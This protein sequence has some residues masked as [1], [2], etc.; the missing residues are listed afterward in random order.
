MITGYDAVDLFAGIGGWSV[1]LRSLGLRALG[2]EIQPHRRATRKAAGFH[3]VLAD[4]R[5]LGHH[6]LPETPGLI[7]SPPCQTF[8]R[9]GKGRGRHNLD[10][11]LLAVKSLEARQV[12]EPDW[13]DPR[14]GLVTEP[15]RWVLDRADSGDPYR[16]VALEQVQPVLPVWQAVGDV[17]IREG[18]SVAVGVVHAEQHGVPQT[19]ARAVL[20]ARL[21]GPVR[22]P[23][24]THSRFYV[25]DR[26]RLDPG[27]LPWVSMADAL[28]WGVELAPP[29][30]FRSEDRTQ[31]RKITE[32]SLTV[33]FGN[34]AGGWTWRVNNQSGTPWDAEFPWKQPAPVI[35]YRPLV[36]FPGAN[37]NRFN[38]ATKSR[39][40]GLR[41][42]LDEVLRLQSFPGDYP[43]QG[44]MSG[45]FRQ[46]GDA[47]PP[48][49]ARALL[50][51]VV[52]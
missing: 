10:Q 16:W 36:T 3:T 30:P 41:V 28:G 25:K 52:R 17:L 43:V 18:Y 35:A 9:A 26:T 31:A 12:V 50:A 2:V 45:R 46:V 51:E 42:T 15:L 47:I 14:T 11:V 48:L 27:V 6:Q 39:N 22:L 34:N 1:G 20:L 7:A 23:R 24:P 4:V 33:A 37:A 38:G 40:D 5:N 29:A 21:D 13:H 19:R 8:S 44:P 32:P 49:L